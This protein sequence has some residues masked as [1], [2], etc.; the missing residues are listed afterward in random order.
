MS[1]GSLK[2]YIFRVGLLF[3]LLLLL[4]LCIYLLKSYKSSNVFK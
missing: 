1:N 4:F 2:K 3:I